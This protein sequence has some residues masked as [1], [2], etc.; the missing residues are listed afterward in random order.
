[1]E[2][3]LDIFLH[4]C[5]DPF[6]F[7]FGGACKPAESFKLF[8]FVLSAI[9]AAIAG[10][11]YVPQ[12]GIINPEEMKPA[13]SL[14]VVVWVAVGGRATLWGPIIGAVF[15]NALKSWATYHYPDSWLIIVGATDFI[16]RNTPMRL[17]SRMRRRSSTV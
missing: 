16:P 4:S 7:L 5:K 14:E 17:M 6:L 8:I 3:F 15:V 2:S 13:K 1:M 12:V 11:L 10:A 9:L